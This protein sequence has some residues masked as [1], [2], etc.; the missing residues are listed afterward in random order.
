MTMSPI[1]V[2]PWND[3]SVTNRWHLQ[4]VIE[5]SLR[6]ASFALVVGTKGN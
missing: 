1:M 5:E 6:K 3:V 4:M 2:T